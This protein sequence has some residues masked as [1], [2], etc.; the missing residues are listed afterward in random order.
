M[1]YFLDVGK[2]TYAL[3]VGMCVLRI[4]W[5]YVVCITC[6]YVCSIYWM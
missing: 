4:R 6:T 1:H 5:T 3:D 2:K